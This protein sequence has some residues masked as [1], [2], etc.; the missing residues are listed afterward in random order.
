MHRLLARQLKRH[1]GK[2][3]DIETFSPEL[4]AFIETLDETYVN[5]D[6]ERKFLEN[7]IS[8]NSEEL[9]SA[10]KKVEQKN[11]ELQDINELLE[12]KVSS[13]TLELVEATKKAEAANEAK[14]KFLANMSHE[15]RTPLNSIIGFSQ[16]LQMRQDLAENYRQYIKKIN[17]AGQNMLVLINTL[18]DFSKVEDNKL[19]FNPQHFSLQGL[20][21]EVKILFEYQVNE[22]NIELVFPDIDGNEMVFA[23]LQ[24]L[25][26]VLINLVS[27][28]I[29]FSP[30]GSSIV[31]KYEKTGQEYCFSVEDHGMGIKEEEMATL[32][33][34]F[35]QG[36][37]SKHI[38]LKGTGLGLNLCKRIVEEL[39]KGTLSCE[40]EW[41]KGSTFTVCL[42]IK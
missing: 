14:S 5:N 13:R 6:K 24:L 30:E 33:D 19:D 2:D 26:Q 11:L 15:L 37:S 22:N 8:L 41:G 31:L 36:E 23:D 16:I 32:F 3:F 25:K 35:T 40:S 1:F 42:P 21:N 38:T 12:D 29:K 17:I 9:H 10:K 20:L 39:H 7:T 34:A 27:N 4:K 18:L 28:A